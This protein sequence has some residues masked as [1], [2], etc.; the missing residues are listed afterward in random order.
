MNAARSGWSVVWLLW[1]FGPIACGSGSGAGEPQSSGPAPDQVVLKGHAVYGHEVRTIR[2]C[3]E[4]E[5][6]WAID[7]TGLLWDLHRELAPGMEPY[8]E[9]FVV[10]LGS[11]GDASSDGFGADY[12][13]S[14]I[15]KQVIYAAGEGFGCD[16]DLSDFSYR[17]SGNEPFWGLT[18]TETT[19]ELSRMD[20]PVRVWHGIRS[21]RF[22]AGVIISAE[23]ND[24]GILE[25][26]LSE[27]P[28]RDSMSGAFYAYTA[29]VLVAGEELRGCAL[30]GAGQ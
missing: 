16:L 20:A 2:P 5:P 26:H 28:C 12:P 13:G 18:L 27:E 30:R 25:V 24:A 7:S 14:F 17:L 15:I 3:G 21:E 22:E 1:V 8:E 19:A 6:V 9:V 11:F 4:A 29:T 10:A 23:R